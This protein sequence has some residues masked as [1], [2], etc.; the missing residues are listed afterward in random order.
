MTC[1]QFANYKIKSGQICISFARLKAKM[2]SVSGGFAIVAA[3]GWVMGLSLQNVAYPT[4][5]LVKNQEVNC[6][7]CSHV[8]RFCSQNL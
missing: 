3:P 2:L 7:K 4:P 6:A 8:D 1:E 5:T